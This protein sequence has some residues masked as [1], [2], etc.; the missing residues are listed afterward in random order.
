MEKGENR[1][2]PFPVLII[3]CRCMNPFPN[4]KI[5]DSSKPKE[6]ADGNFDF[7][8]NGRNFFKKVENTMGKGKICSI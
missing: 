6:F 8:K 3:F 7:I 5:L 1:K 4:D 2:F